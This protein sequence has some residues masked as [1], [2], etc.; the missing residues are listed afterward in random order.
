MSK[1]LLERAKALCVAPLKF[2]RTTSRK[3][4]HLVDG[5]SE[6]SICGMVLSQYK[7]WQT[8]CDAPTD[9]YPICESCK[10]VL[11]RREFKASELEESQTKFCPGCNEYLPITD[12]ARIRSGYMKGYVKS[13][14]KKCSAK[15]RR[16][17]N[18]DNAE[19]LRIYSREYAYRTGKR[20]PMSKAKDAS[21]YL[22]V[23]IAERA[24]SNFFDNITRMPNCNPGFDFLCG[25][26]F[27]IDVKSS[28]LSK[29]KGCHGGW[30]FCIKKN[31]T[32]DYFLCLAFDDRESLNPMH[33]WLI[34]GYA[35]NDLRTIYIPNSDKMFRWNIYERPLDR[36]LGCCDKIR[37]EG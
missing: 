3:R 21:G 11:D 9:S 16:E 4:W 29:T 13:P 18:A 6:K 5:G 7:S 35:V 8:L 37:Q 27:K 1:D 19:R 36:V 20:R 31:K 22:G 30:H 28:C 10:L 15:W 23:Y 14:C 17:W 33:V 12:F 24:L 2:V 32:A 34:P 25:R 26:G